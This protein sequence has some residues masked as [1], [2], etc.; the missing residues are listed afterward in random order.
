MGCRPVT[1]NIIYACRDIA[2]QDPL[3][4]YTIGPQT[5]RGGLFIF[6]SSSIPVIRT[7]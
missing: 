5:A 6:I 2:E 4:S 3:Q 1:H 7:V